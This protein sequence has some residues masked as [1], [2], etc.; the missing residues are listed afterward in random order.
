MAGW[1]VYILLCG[2]GTLYTGAS[3][4]VERRLS[5]HLRGKGA[6]YTRSRLPLA[7]IFRESARGRGAALRRE[8]AIKRL[9]RSQKL[10]LV[11]AAAGI[12][13]PARDG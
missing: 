4:D 11:G 7:L 12:V 3:N 6:A 8:A 2:D 5:R 10:A 13:R 1:E 9:S